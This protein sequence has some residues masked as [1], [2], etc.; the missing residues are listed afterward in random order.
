MEHDLNSDL[1][2]DPAE[3]F[4]RDAT[5]KPMRQIGPRCV[6]TVLAMLSGTTPQTFAGRIN[7]QDPASWSRALQPFGMKLAYCPTDVRKA[8]FYV[9]ELLRLDDLFTV[10]YYTA[11][12]PPS[13]LADPDAEGWAGGSH[14]VIL[15]RDQVLDPATGTRHPATHWSGAGKHTKR[16]FRVVPADHA[17]G[18]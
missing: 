17:R 14:I 10:S 13:I 16:I 7:T 8:K 4:F 11:T 2:P 1:W 5:F 12:D 18:L 15:H 9:P 6:A 3:H